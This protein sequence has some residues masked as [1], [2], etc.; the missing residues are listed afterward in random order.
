MPV[1]PP[2][3]R[4]R[5]IW[6]AAL[7]ACALCAGAVSG[8]GGIALL[9]L[10]PVALLGLVLLVGRYPGEGMLARSLTAPRRRRRTIAAHRSGR[11]R[12]AALPAA[13]C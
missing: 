10:L 3:A 1:S 4:T 6:I 2:T 8:A 7:A 9:H 12:L 13:A 11:P 5:R